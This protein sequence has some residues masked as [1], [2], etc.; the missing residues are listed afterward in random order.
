MHTVAPTKD[1]SAVF[2]KD[3]VDEFVDQQIATKLDGI[4]AQAK[5]M[6]STYSKVQ[7][8]SL[9]CNDLPLSNQPVACA[10]CEGIVLF[11]R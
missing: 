5:L 4:V 8:S 2:E 11:L 6:L 10:G 7:C 9:A 1:A 3:N